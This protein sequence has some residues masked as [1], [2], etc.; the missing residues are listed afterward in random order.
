[1]FFALRFKGI[2]NHYYNDYLPKLMERDEKE[3]QM[4]FKFLNTWSKFMT[5]VVVLLTASASAHAGLIYQFTFSHTINNVQGTTT[6]KIYGLEDNTTGE[7]TDIKLEST[8][9]I[10][11]RSD[12]SAWNSFR[13]NEYTM[14]NGE[15]TK[16]NMAYI[17][18]NHLSG[19]GVQ[20]YQINMT[21]G[22]D[23]IGEDLGELKF[24]QS[25]FNIV[26]SLSGSGPLFIT[27]FTPTE[28]EVPEPSTLAI[29]ALGMMGLASR[30]FKKQS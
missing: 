2:I 3:Y 30:R 29:F 20:R 10:W 24:T 7:A 12:L 6:G 21:Y 13:S 28:T 16:F 17:D 22:R 4:K 27:A 26:Q 14:E 18:Y 25:Y 23:N 15:L 11:S 1:M 19:L 8:H 5:I 9:S